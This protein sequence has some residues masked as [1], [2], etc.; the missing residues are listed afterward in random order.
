MYLQDA[1]VT[2]DDHFKSQQNSK[3][4]FRKSVFDMVPTDDG[5]LPTLGM[6]RL[7]V[8]PWRLFVEDVLHVGSKMFKKNVEEQI[9]W[10]SCSLTKEAISNH[11]G[12][13]L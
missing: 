3:P 6:L 7:T 1:P 5:P 4:K 12:S 8:E 11:H 9:A 13:N 10:L 2:V